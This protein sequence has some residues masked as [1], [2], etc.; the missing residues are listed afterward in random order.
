MAKSSI[1]PEINTQPVLA[2]SVAPGTR[3][4]RKGEATG[5]PGQIVTAANRWR[6][7]YNPLR[8]LTMRR[9]VELFELGQRGDT[10]YL[11]WTYRFIERRNPTLSGLISRCEAPLA[12][13]DWSIKILPKLPAGVTEAQAKAQQA[14]LQNAYDRLDNLRQA[15]LH[16]HSADFRGY[17]HLQ[18]HRNPDGSIFHLEPLMQWTVCRDGLEGNWFWNPD[19]QSTSQPLQFLG[20]DFCIGGDS[21]PRADFIIREC[22]RPIDEIGLVDTVR[23]GLCE[24]DWDG[25]IE[26]Y[27]I[28][29]G[30]VIMPPDV[31]QGQESAYQA[32]ALS[33]SEGAAG[34]LPHGSSYE[35]NSSPRAVDPFSPRLAWLDGQLVLAGTGGKLSM[36]TDHSS[37]GMRGSSKVHDDTFSEIAAGRAAQI[38][39]VMQAQFDSEIL[40]AQFP[41]QPIVAYFDFSSVDSDDVSS[42]ITNVA[43]LA[44]AGIRTDTAWLAERT[45]Y[46]LTPSA[47][48]PAPAPAPVPP[49]PPKPTIQ[50]R[51]GEPV[52]PTS[53]ELHQD[54]PLANELHA[55]ISPLAK[56]LQA[57]AQVSDP[58]TQ[59]HLISKLL[60]DFP[61]IAA[62]IK[63][64]PGLGSRIKTVLSQTMA[65]AMAQPPVTA[66]K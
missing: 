57:I 21:L 49:E 51:A 11:Q 42:L 48:A 44:A 50:N 23:R 26:I 29:G 19:S 46:L 3:I 59:G 35:P 61:H 37:G 2:T 60:T 41:G 45:G 64:D 20:E 30:V 15:L 25:F 22:P 12:N 13:F 56:R 55:A 18:K 34:A 1:L 39:E 9:V 8:N 40:A 38:S 32:A 58:A 53:T 28:P 14:A 66:T 7:N 17:A 33:V 43:A 62:A 36:L 27:G 5:R 63:A 54:A 4:I 24:K 52:A 16:L 31:P 6:E 65:E 47:P 10:A